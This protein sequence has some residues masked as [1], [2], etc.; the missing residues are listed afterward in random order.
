MDSGVGGLDT[1]SSLI[2]QNPGHN[3]FYIADLQFFPYGKKDENQ[4]RERLRSLIIQLAS[5]KLDAVVLACNT[6]TS[7]AIDYLK[8]QFPDI[9]FVGI[10]PCLNIKTTIPGYEN[11]KLAC[12]VTQTMFHSVRFKKLQQEFDPLREIACFACPSLATAVENFT[13]TQDLA[14]L[15][16]KLEENLSQLKKDHFNGLI[17]GCTHYPLISEQLKD[18]LQMDLI[19]AVPFVVSQVREKFPKTSRQTILQL[20][21]TLHEEGL[22]SNSRL[23]KLKLK[24]LEKIA[25]S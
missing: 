20:W 22:S 7:V 4:I 23:L 19:S 5:K 21:D 9:F 14:E 2:V 25:I 11:K 8:E 18:Y 13:A 3:Y 15:N 24:C 17:L 6:A 16:S 1:L 12:I 10:E